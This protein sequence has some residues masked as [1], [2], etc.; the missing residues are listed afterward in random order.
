MCDLSGQAGGP[1]G[2]SRIQ[3]LPEPKICSKLY[4]NCMIL[5]KSWET[6][7]RGP[8]SPRLDRPVAPNKPWSA[9]GRLNLVYIQ[10]PEDGR[11]K[12]RE[13]LSPARQRYRPLHLADP[14]DFTQNRG[15]RS[16][17]RSLTHPLLLLPGGG[18]SSGPANPWNPKQPRGGWLRPLTMEPQFLHKSIKSW[19]SSQSVIEMYCESLAREIA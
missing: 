15:A 10:R 16:L 7:G 19:Y 6:G 11:R 1:R 8:Q 13:A 4:E 18:S 14:A 12:F 3:G 2:G 17:M 9:G 5:K